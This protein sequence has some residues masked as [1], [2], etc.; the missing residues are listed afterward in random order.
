MHECACCRTMTRARI[1]DDGRVRCHACGLDPRST[2][3]RV[4][5]GVFTAGVVAGLLL[6]LP[7]IAAFGVAV[8]IADRI[9]AAS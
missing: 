4:A 6:A 1:D 8:A 2:A 5:E 7:G 9:E 3:Q